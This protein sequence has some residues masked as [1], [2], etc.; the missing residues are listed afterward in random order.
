MGQ[1]HRLT[2]HFPRQHGVLHGGQRNRA[3]DDD[4]QGVNALGKLFTT[5]PCHVNHAG[6]NAAQGLDDVAHVNT[7]PH[8][9]ARSARLPSCAAWLARKQ[10]A[11]IAGTLQHR[12]HC[13]ESDLLEIAQRERLW[14]ANALDAYF[15]GIDVT[16][17]GR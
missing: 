1:R 3:L 5:S 10:R 13:V 14:F 8:H 6:R 15:P 12:R 2:V 7:G 17:I 9:A 11:T 16:N 4:S